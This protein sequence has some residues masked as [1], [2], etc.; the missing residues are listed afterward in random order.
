M[1]VLVV[2]DSAL[3]R[4]WLK[5][6]MEEIGAEVELARN[7]RDALRRLASFEPDVVTLDINMPEMDGL[8]CLAHIMSTHP[9]PVVMLSSLTSKGALATLEALEL[10]AVD[11]FE[12]PG[13]TVSHA[14]HDDFDVIQSKVKAAATARVPSRAQKLETEAKPAKA[15]RAKRSGSAR[16]NIKLVLFGVSTGGPGTVETVLSDLDHNLAAPVVIALHMP[17]RFVGPFA[18]RLTTR[19]GHRLEPLKR[20]M[21]LEPG[22]IYVAGADADV[23]VS[24]RAGTPVAIETPIDKDRIWHPSIDRMVETAMA[25]LPPK[26][27]LAVQLT[28]M[29]DDGA[30][31]MTELKNQGGYTIAEAEETA[32]IFG[33]PKELINRGGASVVLP[34]SAIGQEINTLVGTRSTGLNR[35]L[36]S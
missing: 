5:Q 28:G 7:G 18:D 1:K 35:E 27:L 4:R 20:S 12:K 23:T 32:V 24:I 9:C 17:N 6:C 13:G 36:A 25:N 10:G 3:M 19:L 22:V 29:G 14:L 30:R 26:N 11:Y 2:D 15:T 16:R 21:K 34:N 33:M 8:T 31:A